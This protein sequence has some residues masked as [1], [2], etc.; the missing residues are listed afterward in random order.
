MT[1]VAVA[2]LSSLAFGI[3]DFLG[4]VTSRRVAPLTVLAVAQTT[5]FVLIGL[6]VLAFGSAPPDSRFVPY[7]V[8]SGVIGVVGVAALWRGLAVGVVSIVAPITAAASSIPVLVG[9]AR[10][11]RPSA[12]QAVGMVSVFVGVILVSRTP[13][14]DAEDAGPGGDR[15]RVA[16]GVGFGL[17]A[18]TCF[19][20]L[21]VFLGDAAD[22]D[23]LWAAFTARIAAMAAVV[24]AVLVARHRIAPSRS[25]MPA[26][27]TIGAIDMAANL[28]MAA[29]TTLGLL[30]V[31]S[32]VI[33]LH[34][35][36][37]M[38]LARVILDERLVR[39]QRVGVV[40]AIAGAAILSAT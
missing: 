40:A 10:G 20:S 31:A 5:G 36:V 23:V 4:G 38:G 30:S 12:L 17:V 21:I 32:V 7:A 1:A 37:T 9:L 6:I 11:E 26:L 33:S 3:S 18:A 29:A 24:A 34:V 22:E 14:S 39:V 35:L 16:A 19:G 27:M 13:D 8:A 25:E 15:R 2:L 28:F